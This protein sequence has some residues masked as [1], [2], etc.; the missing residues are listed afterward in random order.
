MAEDS[1][2]RTVLFAASMHMKGRFLSLICLS[3]ATTLVAC[4]GDENTPDASV[5]ADVSMDAGVSTDTGTQEDMG[6]AMDMGA[7][8]MG[9]ART[10]EP[11]PNLSYMRPASC[12]APHDFIGLVQGMVTD[13]SGQPF[14]KAIPQVCIRDSND[15][16]VCLQ[17]DVEGTCATGKWF[18]EIP[19]ASQ[20]LK[21]VVMRLTAPRGMDG[22]AATYCHIETGSEPKLTV[23]DP[24]LLYKTDAPTTLPA[25]GDANTERTVVFADGMEI[26]VTPAQLEFE[27]DYSKLSSHLL[28]ASEPR[29]C[30][31]EENHGFDGIYAFGVEIDVSGQGFPVRIPNSKNLTA[32]TNVEL[33][34]QGALSCKTGAGAE[35]EEAEWVSVGMA[36]VSQDGTV[37]EGGRV[38]CLNWLGYIAR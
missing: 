27:E 14:A 8:D 16:L 7:A 5:S 18:T 6:T 23:T 33:Y 1:R 15:T 20:C 3:T 30:F 10:C 19:A 21:S 4:N 36:Q 9:M 13:T 24:F 38:P 25:M 11:D 17:P 31:L 22:Y 2:R 35:I 26:D 34:V 32:G 29:P 12:M 37:I 28:T